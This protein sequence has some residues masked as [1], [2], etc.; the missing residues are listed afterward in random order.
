MG[1]KLSRTVA[2]VSQ[3]RTSRNGES[4]KQ[5]DPG[6]KKQ[7]RL[8][9]GQAA[10]AWEKARYARPRR[11]LL[12]VSLSPTRRLSLLDGFDIVPG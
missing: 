10:V 12:L 3:N 1:V 2:G 5:R 9:R 11:V 8:A 4:M 6:G 7:L